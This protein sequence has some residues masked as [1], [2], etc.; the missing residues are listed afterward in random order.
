MRLL[1]HRQRIWVCVAG[2]SRLGSGV[3]ENDYEE[4]VVGLG[5]ER[6]TRRVWNSLDYVSL[7]IRAWNVAR[8]PGPSQRVSKTSK[9]SLLLKDKTIRRKKLLR[10][11]TP[12]ESFAAT[13]NL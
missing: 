6:S 8:S 3:G 9:E 11:G 5:Q 7:H 10:G 12:V 2:V 1:W 4:P 13:I